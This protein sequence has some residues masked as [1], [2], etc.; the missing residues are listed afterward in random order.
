MKIAILTRGLSNVMGG[1]ERQLLSIAAGLLDR[2]HEVTIISLDESAARP[3]FDSDSRLKFVGL[4]IG[5]SA[6]KATF[7]ERFQR[8]M[9]VYRLFRELKIEIAL[10]FMTGSYWFSV[11]PARMAGMAIILAER[12]GPSIYSRTRVRHFKSIIFASMLLASAITVQFESYR[13][14]YPFYLR[15]RIVAIPNK[16]PIIDV[17]S[18]RETDPFI[19]LF[20]GR[21]SNQKQIVELVLA[22]LEFNKKHNK[23][24]LE[25]YGEGEQR[26]KIEGI[27]NDN[28]AENIIR[29]HPATKNIE[30]VFSTANV[31]I[32]PSL[33]EGFPNSV[34]EALAAGLPVGGFSDCEGVRDL[35]TPGRNGWLIDRS[36]PILSQIELLEEMYRSRD[37]LGLYSEEAHRSMA[38][39][40]GEEPNEN[41]DQ[42]I[43][44]LV[45]K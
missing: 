34:A 29:I 31:M 4:S 21:L 25:I 23:T 35:I 2:G 33:W 38:R 36:D 20:A 15:K 16:I 19:F 24:K 37:E 18:R 9:K 42:L 41:W 40:Q 28:F 17:K 1:M 12:N 45:R 10:S 6:I 22:F 30:R 32:A 8:Q 5:D 43:G 11:L 44:N 13:N 14:S 7:T 39:Y 3:F 26:E 27:V